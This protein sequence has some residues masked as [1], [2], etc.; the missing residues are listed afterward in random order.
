MN[1]EI[2]NLLIQD[3][4]LWQGRVATSTAADSLPSVILPS[5]AS[6]ASAS[7]RRQLPVILLAAALTTVAAVIFIDAGL[8]TTSGHGRVES[9]GGIDISGATVDSLQ[10]SPNW[11]GRPAEPA[12]IVAAST[13][14]GNLGMPWRLSALSPDG[15]SITINYVAGDGDCVT[16]TGIA[17]DE[18]SSYVA[19]LPI[20]S[21]DTKQT[22]C[23]STLAVERAVIQL[24]NPLGQR[25]LL[26]PVPADAY[27]SAASML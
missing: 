24:A 11:L 23:A 4:R 13:A 5:P 22:A 2:D 6:H 14:G 25:R 12:R 1:D 15:R 18:A 27:S 21:H 8:H 19:I 17:V 20:S 3:A 26:H 16:P 10:L 7:R 9:A